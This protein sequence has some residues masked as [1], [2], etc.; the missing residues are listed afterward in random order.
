MNIT[1]LL[2]IYLPCSLKNRTTLNEVN[3]TIVIWEFIKANKNITCQ[4]G[5]L[6][7]TYVEKEKKNGKE[8]PHLPSALNRT[9]Y[10][11]P[12]LLTFFFFFLKFCN[13]YGCKNCIRYYHGYDSRSYKKEYRLNCKLYL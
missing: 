12:L 9:R 1:F 11:C 4:A 10:R 13:V 7:I 3:Y 2:L 8:K 6:E 5:K